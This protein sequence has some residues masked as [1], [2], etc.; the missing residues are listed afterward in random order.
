VISDEELAVAQVT[1]ALEEGHFGPIVLV[2]VLPTFAGPKPAEPFA[3]AY[4]GDAGVDLYTSEEV[5][6]RPGDRVTV[7]TGI[8]LA[9]PV[10]FE[11]QV[12]PRSGL[13]KNQGLTIVNSPGTIDEGFR[14]EV[15]VF[16]HN[17]TPVV[18]HALLDRLLSVLL[19]DA[20]ATSL[21]EDIDLAHAQGTI[22]LA[23]GSKIGQLVFARYAA[24]TVRVVDALPPS[25]RGTKGMGSSDRPA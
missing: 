12:R 23:R 2:Q 20:D 10:G 3:R 1:T 24:P 17:T 5:V 15:E 4:P 22:H 25:A 13:A 14:G 11:A 7:K 9:L 6:L 21:Q 16:L 8:A 19:E 18:S